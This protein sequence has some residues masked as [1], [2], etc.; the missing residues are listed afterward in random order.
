MT[1]S[2]SPAPESMLVDSPPPM[3]PSFDG[4][5]NG[6]SVPS[7]HYPQRMRSRNTTPV[8]G[9]GGA[10]AAPEP[11]SVVPDANRGIPSVPRIP[12]HFKHRRQAGGGS[13][14]IRD[15]GI[16]DENCESLVKRE[17]DGVAMLDV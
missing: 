12:M 3:R 8:G 2:P 1:P 9:I 16:G 4:V 7:F 11:L 13:A 17:D 14:D 10:A 15:S 5:V 6:L